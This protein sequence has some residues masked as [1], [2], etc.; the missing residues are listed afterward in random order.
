MAPH[1]E[2]VQFNSPMRTVTHVT[3]MLLPWLRS[4]CYTVSRF[5]NTNEIASA[6][7]LIDHRSLAMAPATTT[8]K[9]QPHAATDAPGRE[10]LH[11]V[12][13]R[14]ELF[15]RNL[16]QYTKVRVLLLLLWCVCVFSVIPSLQSSCDT[17][18]STATSRSLGLSVNA[19]LC[20]A[21]SPCVCVCRRRR[22]R[23]TTTNAH[24]FVVELVH[25]ASLTYLLI[26]LCHQ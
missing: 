4:Q 23:R 6:K 5:V 11:C 8:Y 16:E 17:C 14:R 3:P 25:F 15:E 24:T 19:H 10:G 12:T 20:T 2:R 18:L 7:T 13:R 22:R 1:L 26:H 9:W 21:V